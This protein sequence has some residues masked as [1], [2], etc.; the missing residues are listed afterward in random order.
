MSTARKSTRK[1]PAKS[2]GSGSSG[3]DRY[4][5]MT[6][7]IISAIEAG[8][9]KPGEWKLPWHRSGGMAPRNVD[10]RKAY[11]GGNH[12]YLWMVATEAEKPGIFGTYNQ[13]SARHCQVRKGEKSSMV[14]RWLEL[15]KRDANGAPMFDP[16]GKPIHFMVPKVF[17]VFGIWQVD[18][19]EGHEG[20]V[21]K[22]YKRFGLGPDGQ[23]TEHKEMTEVIAEADA[24]FAAVGADVTHGGD[25]AA[26][27]P[28]LDQ[29]MLPKPG[30]FRDAIAYNATKGH[31][32]IHWTGHESRLGR[33]GIA[34][35]DGF[36]TPNYAFEE[37]VAEM[38][39]AFLGQ[40]LGYAVEPREDHLHYVAHWLK[41][42]KADPKTLWK[43][44]REAEAA[45]NHLAK[46]AGLADELPTD[47]E[48][49]GEV[50]LGTAA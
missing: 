6:E 38:G 35:F 42:L 21:A 5:E 25:T 14:L 7:K 29:I 28:K 44:A 13:W 3:A 18:D 24:F 9:G 30:Q 33:D 50:G 48:E 22:A 46:L 26:Y 43:A 20:A 16:K 23:S 45:V 34:K 36:G 19:A 10:S 37:L 39:S 4:A 47:E 15:Q 49:G 41:G 8:V 17:A 27:S 40:R 1:A 11:Q 32:H 31:E 12:L 2:R